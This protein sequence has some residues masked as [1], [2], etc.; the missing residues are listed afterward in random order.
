MAVM[1]AVGIDGSAPGATAVRA[2]RAW[3]EQLGGNLASQALGSTSRRVVN[4]A[5]CG[6]LVVRDCQ[7]GESP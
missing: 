1:K 5:S 4:R 2:A 6:A 7:E 3:V